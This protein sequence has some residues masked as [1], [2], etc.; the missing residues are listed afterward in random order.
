MGQKVVFVLPLALKQM[1][2]SLGGEVINVYQ[3]SLGK[4]EMPIRD[5][6]CQ[7][8]EF[9]KGQSSTAVNPDGEG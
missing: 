1:M 6:R 7:R 8:G 4:T 2:E 3:H 5:S 9:P